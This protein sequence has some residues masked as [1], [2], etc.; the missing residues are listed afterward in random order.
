MKNNKH[1][2]PGDYSKE[3]INALVQ[4]FFMWLLKDLERAKASGETI[5]FYMHIDVE[6]GE[7]TSLLF[8]QDAIDAA[9]DSD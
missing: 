8:G 1:T 2:Q 3:Q 4:D 7:M 9:A 5:P 6:T